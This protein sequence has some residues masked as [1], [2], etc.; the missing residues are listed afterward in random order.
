MFG[1]RDAFT[2]DECAACG[3]LQR[4]DAPDMATYYPQTYYAF[5]SDRGVRAA[6]RRR[7]AAYSFNGSSAVVG[8]AVAAVMGVDDALA[9]VRDAGVTQSARLLDVGSGTGTLLAR[10]RSLGF[11]DLT[12]VDPLIAADVDLGAGVRV[13]KAELRDVPGSFDLVMMHHVL[14]H[15]K[16]PVT[17]L[18]QAR[19]RLAPKGRVL[20][21]VPVAGTEAWRRYG[22][23]WV[24]LDAPRHAVVPTTEGMRLG[25]G[26]AGLRVDRVVF[27]SSEFQFW[28]S[29]QY[30]RDIPLSDPR[31]LRSFRQRLK[32]L[33]AVRRWRREA[34][35]L[36]RRN[37]GDQACFHLSATE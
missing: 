32:H 19:E 31:S 21:R 15:V 10:L 11:Q 16:D 25:A 20:V 30:A 26:R 7:W 18:K 5:Q 1:L 28:G 36:N 33:R 37:E 22:A 23:H 12:G 27:D 2:Y 24:Q 29:E 6:I 35:E 3:S 14:E 34:R 4:R 17:L 13:L 8:R 9:A